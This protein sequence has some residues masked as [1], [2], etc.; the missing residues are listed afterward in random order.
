MKTRAP[1]FL[2]IIAGV[3]VSSQGTAKD[4]T[5][6][7]S[8]KRDIFFIGRHFVGDIEPVDVEQVIEDPEVVAFELVELE[9]NDKILISRVNPAR[10][11]DVLLVHFE[12]AFRL[13]RKGR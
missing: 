8:D 3:A 13:Q 1:V 9:F 11:D 12:N 2:E 6:V 5:G 4:G 10:G 7:V